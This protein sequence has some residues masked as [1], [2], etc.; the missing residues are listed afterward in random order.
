MRKI[1][2]LPDINGRTLKNLDKK[3][4]PTTTTKICEERGYES[5]SV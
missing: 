1:N 4:E 3:H 2:Y 5:D